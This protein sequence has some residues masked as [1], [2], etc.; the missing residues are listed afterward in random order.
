MTIS[1]LNY[2]LALGT[3]LIQILAVLLVV[4]FILRKREALG[5]TI[6]FVAK[7][8]LWI[9]FLASLAG[10][11]IAL[12]YSDVLGFEACYWCYWQRYFL[13]PQVI[14]L[15]MA[16][17]KK[18]AYM[19]DYSIILSVAGG[20]V[21]LYHHALQM[22]PGS[23]LPC[24]ATGVSCAQRI[25]FEFGYITYPLMAFSVF[26]FLVVILAIVRLQGRN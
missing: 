21:A 24:P 16:A 14:L 5:D 26:A 22:L 18:D 7:W 8:G 15:G 1:D 23:G 12:Y 11:T 20:L 10:T 2:L 6:A 9:G 4:F 25:F 13:F 17:W 19:A 3:V